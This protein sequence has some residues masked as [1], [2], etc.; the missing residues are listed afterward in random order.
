MFKVVEVKKNKLD[1]VIK[2]PTPRGKSVITVREVK[3]FSRSGY[4]YR[5]IIKD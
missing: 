3:R 5:V 1:G 2:L 4:P